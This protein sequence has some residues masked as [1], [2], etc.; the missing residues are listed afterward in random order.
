MDTS[1]YRSFFCFLGCVV[2]VQHVCCDFSTFDCSMRELALE[3]AQTIQP[4]LTASQLQDIHDALKGSIESTTCTFPSSAPTMPISSADPIEN[5]PLLSAPRHQIQNIKHM[6]QSAQTIA[7]HIDT[8]N[9]NDDEND[10]LSP[11]TSLKTIDGALGMIEKI[12]TQDVSINYEAVNGDYGRDVTINLIF[13]SGKYVIPNT[14]HVNNE[15]HSNIIFSNYKNDTPIFTG[16]IPIKCDWKPMNDSI[17]S[18]TGK[19]VKNVKNR[20]NKVK[21]TKK[22]IEKMS[23]SKNSKKSHPDPSTSIYT[24][25]IDSSTT[26]NTKYNIT[27]IYGLRVNG[28]RGIRARYPNGNPETDGFGSELKPLSYLPSNLPSNPNIL[29]ETTSTEVERYSSN[30]SPWPKYSIGIGGNCA[31]FEPD[32]SFWCA[33]GYSITSGLTYNKSILPNAPYSNWTDVIVQVWRASHWASWMF[34]VDADKTMQEREEKEQR[35]FN[36]GKDDGNGANDVN[37]IYFGRGG[38]QGARGGSGEEFYIENSIFELDSAN[39]WYYNESESMLYYYVNETYLKEMNQT[40]NDLEFEIV[41]NKVLFELI[42]NST[43]EPVNNVVFENIIFRDTAYTYLDSHSVPSGG[44][45]GL[46]FKGAIICTNCF[47][48]LIQNCQFIRL[49]GN[50]IFLFGYNR[51]ITIYNNEF[52]WIGD[53]AIALWGITQNI[54]NFGTFD[55]SGEEH[56]FS[57]GYYEGL[58]QTQPRFIHVISNLVHE[59]GIWEK[60]SSFYFQAKSCQN[61]IGYNIFYNGP[62][63]GINFNDGF[64]GNSVIYKNL[65]FN[66]CRESSDHGPFNSWDRQ[67]F[68]TSMASPD[69]GIMAS[70]I[71]RI[72]SNSNGNSNWGSPIDASKEFDYLYENFF[73][74]NYGST[75]PIDNDDGSFLYHSYSNFLVYG[76]MGYKSNAGGYSNIHN[77]NVYAY[78]DEYCWNVHTAPDNDHL[79]YWYNNTCVVQHDLTKTGNKNNG[80]SVYNY[81]YNEEC[82]ININDIGIKTYNNSIYINGATEYNIGM[83]NNVSEHLFQTVYHNDNFTNIYGFYP[84]DDL[85][86]NLARKLVF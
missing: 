18:R 75:W 35:E 47:N 31:G 86:L 32:I 77:N 38:F 49:D 67:L 24:C 76:T 27:K 36:L 83:C 62:R 44:D 71:D 14:I 23:K 33:H 37:T 56:Y 57:Y 52:S 22:N 74:A 66:T 42:G 21:N 64:G 16:A 55:I 5:D 58:N 40:I 8:K 15:L 34:E 4:N 78:V 41:I 7:L 59:L 29:I 81:I 2:L 10:G 28:Q 72:T 69:S 39:E 85:L 12:R 50:G 61:V 73:I 46:D 17:H 11:E 54:N 53:T 9:G 68:L 82:N 63:A 1:S 25:H 20:K 48:I 51:N 60:Q 45:W 84:H 65:L 80:N 26:N 43:S 79:N 6:Q 70:N 30:T 3:F 19:D 13:H